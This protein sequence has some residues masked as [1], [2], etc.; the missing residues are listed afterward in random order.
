[1]NKHDRDLGGLTIFNNIFDNI[2][3]HPTSNNI[4]SDGHLLTIVVRTTLFII[5]SYTKYRN[6]YRV[7]AHIHKDKTDY[8]ND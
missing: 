6:T 1:M 4:H 2:S 7:H 3:I 8:R 5:E